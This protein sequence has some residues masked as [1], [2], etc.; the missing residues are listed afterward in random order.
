MLLTK[1]SD[2]M[3]KRPTSDNVY[4]LIDYPLDTT[5]KLLVF[6]IIF[7]FIFFQSTIFAQVVHRLD[8]D[9]FTHY[10]VD[11]WISYAPALKITSVDMDFEYVYFAT[12]GGGI[13]RFNKYDE[14]WG[15]PFTTSAGLRSNNI[16]QVVYNADDGFLYAKTPAGIDVYKPAERYWQPSYINEMPRRREPNEM[17]LQ[18]L[19]RSDYRFPP[20]YRPSNEDLPDF[21]TDITLTYQLGGILF[22]QY[23][24]EFRLLDRIVDSWQRIW[25]GTDGMGPIM[26]DMYSFRLESKVQSIPSISPRD[27]FIDDDIMWIGGL[28]QGLSVGGITRWDRKSHEWHYFEAP[29]ISQLYKDD[30]FAISGNRKYILFAT[31]HGL[32]IYNRD[33]E[34]WKTLSTQ[35]GMEG[36]RLFD[37][38]VRGDTAYVGTEFGFNWIDLRSM[39][40]YESTNTTLDHVKIRQLAWDDTLIWAAT[41]H[42]LYSIDIEDDIINFHASRA[43]SIDYDLSAIEIVDHEIWIANYYGIA[44]W[45]RKTGQWRSFPGLDFKADIRDI[46]VTKNV[47]WFATSEG[48]LKYDQK[49]EYWRL[50]TE[51][52]GLLSND[53]FHIDPED[54][55]LWISTELGIC[56]FRWKRQG[57]ID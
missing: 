34:V 18:G 43:A 5:L 21:F 50:F 15:Y 28:N 48:L 54:D 39:K 20:L 49:R 4:L 29:F 30:V 32:A 55:R 31:I 19:N 51:K 23:N 1:L 26:A 35:H 2:F 24:R 3:K 45:N 47:L 6:T 11:D 38:L 16:T 57:R 36:D 56:S 22:D 52:D 44:H 12:L 13:L 17:D 40:V 9:R 53:I 46:A 25:F 37:V 42:G 27:V 14:T 8:T 7:I 33:R 41:R 10:R